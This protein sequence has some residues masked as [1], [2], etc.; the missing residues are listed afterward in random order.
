MLIVSGM[1]QVGIDKPSYQDDR[2]GMASDCFWARL[3][4]RA[5]C[6]ESPRRRRLRSRASRPAD[7]AGHVMIHARY[8][9]PMRLAGRSLSQS[10]RRGEVLAGVQ[11]L[12][13][14]S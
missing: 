3:R 11:D 13:K 2:C 1:P 8:R 5:V 14:S 7:D 9:R 10:I 4:P 6:S 12:G